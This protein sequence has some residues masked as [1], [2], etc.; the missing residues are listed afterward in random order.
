[1]NQRVVALVGISGV[2]KTTFVKRVA[3][4]CDFLHLT[5]GTLIAR[6]RS[7]DPVTR[8]VLRSSNLEENQR[9]LVDGFKEAAGA[10]AGPIVLD[11][12]VVIHMASGLAPID[13]RVFAGIGTKLVAHL[14]ANPAQI[15]SNRL[16]DTRR[17][18]PSLSVEELEV[19][20]ARS[21]AA[22]RRVA[23]DLGIKLKRLTHDDVDVFAQILRE[24]R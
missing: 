19:H 10:V 15:L 5:A 2:G 23:V 7:I 1:M 13:S 24:P 21:L 18:R 3:E 4:K 14:E 17:D 16:C 8:D 9:M 11:G 12:H 6:G 20:Q 22:A